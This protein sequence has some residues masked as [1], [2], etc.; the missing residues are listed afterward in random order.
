MD[1]WP[2]LAGVYTRHKV[3]YMWSSV[4]ENAE[5][6]HTKTHDYIHLP[7][8]SLWTFKNI[9]HTLNIWKTYSHRG[10]FSSQTSIPFSYCLLALSVRCPGCCGTEAVQWP[11][12]DPEVPQVWRCSGILQHLRPA[13]QRSTASRS[14]IETCAGS[15]RA[16]GSG[17]PSSTGRTVLKICFVSLFFVRPVVTLRVSNS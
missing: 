1:I 2:E 17:W 7:G 10:S 3:I 8:T 12:S 11:E 6:L 5:Q 15:S 14:L 16:E 13:L 4:L 9:F